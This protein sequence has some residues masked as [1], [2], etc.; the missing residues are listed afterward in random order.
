MFDYEW[1]TVQHNINC[2]LARAVVVPDAIPPERL[3]AL[4]GAPA[5][6]GR[7]EGLKE[8]YYLAD[9]EPDDG[10]ARGARARSPRA[11]SCVVRTPPEVS[12]Y[13]RFENDLFAGVLERLRRPR[14]TRRR[15]P[16]CCRGSTPSARELAACRRLHRP[17]ARDRRPVA[18]RPRRPRDLRRRHD[19][20]RGRR[21]RDARLH[22][23][24]GPPRGGRRAADRRRPAARASRT[25]EQLELRGRGRARRAGAR[26]PR[27]ATCSSSCCCRPAALS[28][29]SGAWRRRTSPRALT[30]CS[31]APTDPLGG[32]PPPP[33]LAAAARSG[34]GA[35]RARVLPRLPAA[36]QQRARRATT[37][38]L[39][40]A[41]IWWVLVGSLPV[42]VLSRVYQ[43]R[44][45]YA[46]QRDYEAIVRAVVGD[47]AADGRRDRGAA[48]GR[49]ATRHGEHRARSV[50]PNGVIVLFALLALVFLVGVRAVAR[51]RLRAPPAGGVPRRRARA[52]APC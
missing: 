12:L 6:C 18:D 3:R 45:R 27:P 2:R 19:E 28:R 1:A 46:G 21:A 20:P 38:S 10:G 5:S 33:P 48:P 39:R 37:R 29:A 22:D 16:S 43:R 11:R 30:I 49:T 4:R 44:W 40:E 25:P 51:E 42:L 41:T 52:S 35:G 8:E 9:F 7:Y 31:N 23:L 13:H 47:R 26:A 34:R 15:R 32:P 24:P 36:L 50:L 17:R 14:P